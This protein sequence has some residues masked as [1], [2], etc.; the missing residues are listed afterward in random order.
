MAYINGKELFFGVTA[1]IGGDG[2]YLLGEASAASTA[3]KLTVT[4]MGGYYLHSDNFV[5]DLAD[6][7]D[8]DGTGLDWG[9]FSISASGNNSIV[10]EDSYS[11][12]A[13]TYGGTVQ[14][15]GSSDS[16]VIAKSSSAI[17]INMT[18]GTIA[19]FTAQDENGDSH[20]CLAVARTGSTYKLY[21][22]ADDGTSA[23][24][25]SVSNNNAKRTTTDVY[26]LTPFFVETADGLVRADDVLIVRAFPD[27]LTGLYTV[28]DKQVFFGTSI[29]LKDG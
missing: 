4:N 3:K 8:W 9:C 23:N 6:V 19:L 18:G 29:A 28:G 26:E 22:A 17:F 15:S 7:W 2:A 24:V 13:N 25:F 12:N 20:K 21:L 27:K 16:V 5:A 14:I 11:N 1:V 10:I